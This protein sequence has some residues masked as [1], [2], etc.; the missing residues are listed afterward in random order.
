MARGK[1]KPKVQV[2]FDPEQFRDEYLSRFLKDK[3]GEVKGETIDFEEEDLVIKRDDDFFRVP[4]DRV[5]LDGEFLIINKRIDWKKAKQQG[6]RWK[7]RELDP[8]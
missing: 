7:K 4:I 3:K 2:D 6:E 8:L 5:E 1:K